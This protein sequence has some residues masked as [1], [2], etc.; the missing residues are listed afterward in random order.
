MGKILILFFYNAG[1]DCFEGD[2]LGRM[3]LSKQGIIDRDQYIFTQARKKHIPICMT[4]SGGYS[5]Q[6]AEI[7]ANSIIN[8]KRK[9]LLERLF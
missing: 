1:T 9:K 2:S 5:Q 4:L 3:K 6:S 7:V 8:L